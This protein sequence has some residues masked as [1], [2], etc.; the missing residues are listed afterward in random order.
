MTVEEMITLGQGLTEKTR[1]FDL[2]YDQQ[3]SA[4]ERVRLTL[5][6]HY[7]ELRDSLNDL[8]GLCEAVAQSHCP[9]K[10]GEVMLGVL[11]LGVIVSRMGGDA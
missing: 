10:H 9:T 3:K 7:G 4:C 11:I 5:E 8:G 6:N 2:T 1:P